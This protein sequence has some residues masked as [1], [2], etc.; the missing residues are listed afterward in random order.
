MCALYEKGERMIT[1]LG[2]AILKVSVWLVPC[3][4]GGVLM[5]RAMTR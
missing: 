1:I 4:I 5:A 2:L 3:I